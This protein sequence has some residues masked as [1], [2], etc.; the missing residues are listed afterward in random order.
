MSPLM[1]AIEVGDLLYEYR[2]KIT[3]M[4][5]FGFSFG[6]LMSGEAAPPPEGA[7]F[8]VAFEGSSVGK[9]T[10]TVAGIDHLRLRADGR[11]DLDIRGTITTHDGHMISLAADG[12]CLPTP[13]NP[14]AAL[15]E[16]VTLFTSAKEYAWLNTLQIWGIGT[17][18]LAEQVVHIKGYTA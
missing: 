4:T 2:V 8:D 7:R 6:A 3:G 17:V 16:N 11:F 13:G 5:E 9:L 18:D 12:V 14:V 15:R 1:S 10:G